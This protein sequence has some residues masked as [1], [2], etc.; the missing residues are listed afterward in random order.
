MRKD[1]RGLILT[2]IF[3]VSISVS[4]CAPSFAATGKLIASNCA[5]VAASSN[6]TMVWYSKNSSGLWE[7]FIGNGEC[8]GEPLL[9]PYSGNRGPAAITPNGR[10]VLL[11]TAVGWEK[12][13]SMSS[14][15]Q[16]SQN[17]IQLYDRQTGKLSTLLAGA[18]SSQRGVIW[19]TFNSNDTKIV[20]SQLVR[21]AA[22]VPPAGQWALHV[23]NVNLETGTLSNNVEWQDPDGK[24]AF[25]EAYGWIPN[26]NL[27]VFMSTT[28]STQTGFRAE[29]L[30]TLPE[31]LNPSTAPTRISPELA[32]A[33]PWQSP[34]NVFHEFAHFAPNE[35]NTLYTSIGAD[36][37]GGND[38]FSYNLQ[39]H[40][41]NGQLGQPARI[42][43]FGGD[44]N[45]NWGTRAMPGW[46]APSY[47]V[48]TTM[49][50]VNGSWVL[51]TCPDLLCSEVNAWR[52]EQLG[53]AEEVKRSTAEQEQEEG[54][55]YG[56]EGAQT[57]PPASSGSTAT[58]P[59]SP[60]ATSTPSSGAPRD[61]AG[62]VA[63]VGPKLTV[64]H[65]HAVVELRCSEQ[66]PCAGTLTL[67]AG[68]TSGHRHGHSSR[69]RA[70]TLG[71]AAFTILPGTSVTVRVPVSG[72]GKKL[73]A[74]EHG[75]LSATL[76]ISSGGASASYSSAAGS[77]QL[78][79]MLVHMSSPSSSW[80]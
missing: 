36:T 13:M 22:E 4:A 44:L 23:A 45:T 16:G 25:Y 21:T 38:L 71:T 43:Y 34:V 12:A 52:I 76:T 18:T 17:S 6:G 60:S 29:Q 72:A 26:T 24:P 35:P 55:E 74:A 57:T 7:T 28:R 30:F 51:T 20:W 15:G 79:R 63:L 11:T 66:G 49:A 1:F 75:K 61:P 47:T 37:V 41:S 10:Y 62:K 59:A 48:V 54:G 68:Y 39:S 58:T 32:P 2:L 64:F 8:Q 53:Q 14:P 65:G 77:D 3:A 42:S 50:W 78:A 40:G 80:L 70:Q 67:S 27:L 33:W 19:P 56:G 46:P 73:L 31:E 69:V 9:P 5:P